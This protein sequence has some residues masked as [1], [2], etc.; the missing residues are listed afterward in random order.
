[1]A[2]RTDTS[3]TPAGRVL[4][5]DNDSDIAEVVT[6]ILGDEGYA[7]ATLTEKDH[8]SIAA[9]VGEQEP[10]CILLDGSAE[11]GFDDSWMEAA[12]LAARERAIPTIMFSAHSEAVAEA[13]DR[14]SQ[15]AAAAHF[16]A[17]VPKPFSIDELVEAVAQACG[18][19]EPFDATP[20]GERARTEELVRR[21]RA[22]GAVDVRTGNRRE[23]A[24]FISSHDEQ[25]YQL[26]WWQRLG[27]YI[28]GRYDEDARLEIVGR[29]FEL[30]AA[31]DAV[32]PAAR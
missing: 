7:V 23:W 26:Y 3:P 31:I 16:A 22:A 1:M 11:T 30:D 12:Y 32:L 20:A 10:D 24:T 18:R 13:R 19:A 17:V 9:A 15:R 6:A 5:V 14:A 28:V 29:H 8:A 4:V 2:E 21:L 25:I 27:L